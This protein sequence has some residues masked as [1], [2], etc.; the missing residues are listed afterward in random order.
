M[1]TKSPYQDFYYLYKLQTIFSLLFQ[2]ILLPLKG[3]LEKG[4]LVSDSKKLAKRYIKTWNFPCDIL[5]LLPTDLAYLYLGFD[6]VYLRFNR[7]LRLSR[8]NEFFDR[9]E[10]RTNYPNSF[11]I[12]HLVLYILVII[13][14][15][16]CFY[17]QVS[18][19]ASLIE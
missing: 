8:L 6:A 7:L 10:S 15:N 13:H 4:L 3:Y 11:R 19:L 2:T 16:G 1:D 14:W 9:T 12:G 5:S 17:F 18:L